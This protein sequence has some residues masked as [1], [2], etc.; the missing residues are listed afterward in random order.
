MQTGIS[1]AVLNGANDPANQPGPSNGQEVGED[2]EELVMEGRPGSESG[3]ISYTRVHPEA[4]AVVRHQP[5]PGNASTG[6]RGQ[7]SLSANG[8]RNG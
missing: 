1:V 4:Q 7:N 5:A 3:P 8:N 2:A 6:G